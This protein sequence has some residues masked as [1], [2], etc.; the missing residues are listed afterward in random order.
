MFLREALK[1]HTLAVRKSHSPLKIAADCWLVDY[2]SPLPRKVKKKL[3]QR[4]NKIFPLLG[5]LYLF[6]PVYR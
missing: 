5:I 1:I 4:L 6:V 2:I 3:F